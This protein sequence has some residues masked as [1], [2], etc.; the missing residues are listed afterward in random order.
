MRY[1]TYWDFELGL[2]SLAGRASMREAERAVARRAKTRMMQ[3][4]KYA[5]SIECGIEVSKTRST[6][7]EGLG[8]GT[9]NI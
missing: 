2:R 9:A 8:V 3:V 1:P 4:C 5:G 6:I 7:A